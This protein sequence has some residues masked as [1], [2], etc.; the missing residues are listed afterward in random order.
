MLY[1]AI[2]VANGIITGRHESAQPIAPETFAASRIFAEHDV[3]D[4]PEDADIIDGLPLASYNDDWTLKPL[5][6]RVAEGLVTV[7][8]GYVLDGEEIRPMTAQERIDAGLDTPPV[9]QKTDERIL[10]IMQLKAELAA[11]DYKVLKAYE[12]ALADEQAPY[13]V[14]AFHAARQTMRDEINAL[15]EQGLQQG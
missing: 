5:S 9:E 10:R 7:D 4:V 2:T 13:D 1:Y 12:Y 8:A 15:E 6:Q 11:S 3:F 14:A